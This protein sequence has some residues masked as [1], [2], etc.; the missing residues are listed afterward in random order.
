MQLWKRA[1]L[2]VRRKKRKSLLLCITIF[3]LSSFSVT[4]L[5]LRS[6]INLAI[7]QTRESLS[8]AFRIAPDMNNAE[9]VKL[10]EVDGQ[11]VINYIGEPLNEK[12]IDIIQRTQ[13]IGAYNAVIKD[14]V[15]IQENI[16]LVDYN[17]KYQ[18]DP[19]AMHFISVEADTSSLY[20]TDFQR[21]RL[22]LSDGRH[23]TADD[24]Y[25]ALVSRNLAAQN[26]WKIG[27]KIQFSPC[28][29][30][31]GQKI[32]VTI[33]GLF[34]IEEKQQ[35]IDIAAP[36]HLLENRIFID[37]T[38]AS[39]L[40]DAKGVDYIDFF[41]NDPAQVI[42]IIQELQKN[43]DINWKCFVVTADIEEYKKISSPLLNMTVLLNVL[44]II[45]GVMS[46]AVLSLIQILFHKA[47]EHEIGIMLS[48]GISKA[49]ML[50]QH[51]SEMIIIAL[52]SFILSFAFCFSGWNCMSIAVCKVTEWNIAMKLNMALAV[53]TIVT[54]FGCGMI[55]LFLS[56]LL[57]NLWLMR[58]SPKK[59]FSSLS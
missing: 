9:N 12:I 43:S 31:T 25:A 21:E 16:S 42:P 17:G 3:L 51:F 19:I 40:T 37:I 33:K 5:L 8:G 29:N 46:I 41:V 50:V 2:Y 11:I 27:D 4:G 55:M 30:C 23:I 10:S 39:Y 53:K 59:I 13:K 38:S 56:V 34:E 48:I 36:V 58:L 18:D 47:R 14:N 7:T 35:N 15:Q 49:E 6:V 45:I 24:T 32:G 26:D 52:T 44:L 54:T 22:K 28:E 20:S 1:Y 57:S